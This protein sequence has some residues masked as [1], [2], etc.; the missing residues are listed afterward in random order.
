MGGRSHTFTILL[1]EGAAQFGSLSSPA[2]KL[3]SGNL[4]RETF[5]EPKDEKAA[6]QIYLDEGVMLL[7]LAR[8]TCELFQRQRPSERRRLLDFVLS[9]CSWKGGELSATF[10]QPF[11]LLAVAAATHKNQMAAGVISNGH[12]ENWLLR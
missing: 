10:R 9:N 12:F 7:E 3:V 11:D 1:I 2:P 4:T 5:A 8:R 6:N